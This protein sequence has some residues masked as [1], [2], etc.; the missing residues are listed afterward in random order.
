MTGAAGGRGD[1]L[2]LRILGP[3][4]G[5]YFPGGRPA[6]LRPRERD[7]AGVLLLRARHPCSGSS[8]VRALWPE[9]PPRHPGAALRVC[10]SRTRAALAGHDFITTVPGGYRA[11][12]PDAALDLDRYLAL[13]EESGRASARRRP[14]EAVRLLK[15]ALDCWPGSGPGAGG[16]PAG[17][18]TAAELS[19]IRA[20][21]RQDEF[22][23]ADT[24]LHLGLHEQVLPVLH[25]RVI[26]DP[27]S[28]RS[29]VQ[30]VT[31]LSRSG[32]QSE[33]LAAWSRARQ[34][35]PGPGNLLQEI[36]EPLAAGR[37]VPAPR[38]RPVLQPCA[39]AA[40]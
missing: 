40:P 5:I 16:L 36:L 19:R 27:A 11:D 33:A 1:A 31:A 2:D 12:P 22:T 10:V 26:A 17:P 3:S 14:R 7:L 23:L 32:R 18:A 15:Q 37:P 6:P 13:R 39:G 20:M 9:R 29:W 24:C 30:L 21:R 25:A 35:V 8:L 38:R 34:S 28:E 4:V